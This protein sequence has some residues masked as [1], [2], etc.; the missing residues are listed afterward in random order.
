M[1]PNGSQQTKGGIAMDV[2]SDEWTSGGPTQIV[3]MTTKRKDGESY[4]D[5]CK[6]HDERVA[7]AQTEFPPDN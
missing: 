2:K 3:T 1:T 7:K 6:R 5:F 4:E